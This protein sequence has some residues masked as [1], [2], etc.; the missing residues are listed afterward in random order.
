LTAPPVRKDLPVPIV[1]S[2]A[3]PVLEGKI[4]PSR[5]RPVQSG[6]EDRLVP[7]VKSLDQPVQKARRESGESLVTLDLPDQQGP[8]PPLPGQPEA[9]AR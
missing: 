9:E 7:T 8:I 5:V 6:A 1:R 2:L 3:Q 4:P